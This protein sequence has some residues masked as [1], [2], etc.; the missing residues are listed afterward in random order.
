M[1]EVLLIVLIIGLFA[2]KIATFVLY[3]G[4]FILVVWLW[5]KAWWGKILA[6]ILGFLII[7]AII[8]IVIEK[9]RPR[10]KKKLDTNR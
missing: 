2:S 6:V 1:I 4:L 7:L 9:I 5:T 8:G 3:L 10:D